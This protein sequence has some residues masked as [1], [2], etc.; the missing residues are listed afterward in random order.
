MRTI[1]V[2]VI[3]VILL[4]PV[5]AT[6]SVPLNRADETNVSGVW[7]SV[8]FETGM[9]Y[10]LEIGWPRIVLIITAG[11]QERGEYIFHA[12]SPSLRQGVISFG[13]QD[14]GTGFHVMASGEM[15]ANGSTGRADISI[16]LDE[17]D[18]SRFFGEW[19]AGPLRFLKRAGYSRT[20]DLARA[21]K[22]SDELAANTVPTVPSP[23]SGS[24]K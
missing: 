6:S 19:K 14:A 15:R 3:L 16:H 20:A 24:K 22:R 4:V 10:R 5:N 7:E 12:N 21:E 8:D 2:S 18:Q 9:Y 23:K 13:A 11:Y 1:L 17:R